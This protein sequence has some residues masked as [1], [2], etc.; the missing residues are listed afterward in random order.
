VT[1]EYL[2]AEQLAAI[3][4]WSEQAIHRM[5]SRGVLRQGVHFFQPF[6]TRSQL[7]FKWRAIVNL[8]EGSNGAAPPRAE[9]PRE[10]GGLDVEAATAALQRMLG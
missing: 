9:P 4:P 3:T 2:N 10:K 1:R 6:G 5:V 7:V 8:I